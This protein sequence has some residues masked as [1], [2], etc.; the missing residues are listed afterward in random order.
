MARISQRRLSSLHISKNLELISKNKISS[1][2]AN[3]K[4]N[5][6][7]DKPLVILLSW[8]LAKRKHVFKFADYYITHGFDVLK[9]NITPWQMLWP[10]KGSQ[11]IANE[12]ATFLDK[13]ST[14]TPLIIH[15][16]SVGG[17]QWGEVLVRFS[18]EP[19]RFQHILD[20]IIGQ[21]WDSAADIS[22]ISYGFPMA[23]F[24]K[25][26]VLQNAM[27]QYIL[28]HMRTFDK[29]ATCHYV[30]SSQLFHSNM[31][32][33]PA[34]FFLSKTDPVGAEKSNFRLKEDWE[35]LGIKVYWQ[36]WDTSPHVGHYQRH[37][38]EYLEKLETFLYEINA[39]TCST[40]LQ[41]K[42]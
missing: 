22:E 11:V 1:D 13:N 26:Q 28:Y 4:L 21:V 8:L 37:R 39:L 31:V 25:N 23:L 9:V 14:C 35:N 33:A 16:F 5:A 29:V 38:K 12:V 20:R 30:R 32:K 41:A 40:K 27:K 15:G 36:C 7:L 24:P 17:Y 42:L 6:T 2:I 18:Q 10:T 19:Q 34:L 3:F